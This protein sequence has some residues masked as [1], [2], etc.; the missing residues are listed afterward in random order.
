MPHPRIG[1]EIVVDDDNEDNLRKFCSFNFGT[2]SH[3]RQVMQQILRLKI[4]HAVTQVRYC[5]LYTR[6]RRHC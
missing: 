4:K 6:S 3:I 2:D 1:P 5:S